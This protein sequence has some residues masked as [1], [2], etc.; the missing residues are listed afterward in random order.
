M[1]MSEQRRL[2]ISTRM[3]PLLFGTRVAGQL[4]LLVRLFSIS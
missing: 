4:E 3:L 1:A 2:C